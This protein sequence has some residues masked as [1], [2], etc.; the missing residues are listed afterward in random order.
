MILEAVALLRSKPNPSD[1]EI[2]S[3][4]NGHICRCGTYPRIVRAVHA[5]AG[6]GGRA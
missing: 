1:A 5:A 3:G 2:V 4:M 6:K